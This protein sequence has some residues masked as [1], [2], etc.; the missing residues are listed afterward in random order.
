MELI[1]YDIDKPRERYI[2]RKGV[3]PVIENF[4]NLFNQLNTK[5]VMADELDLSTE[6]GQTLFNELV[7]S[8]YEGDVFTNVP[9]CPCGH[10]VGGEKE[11]ENCTRC[12]Y[13]CQTP[14]EQTIEPLVWIRAPKNVGAFLNPQVYQMLMTKMMSQGF[15]T[16][17]WLIDPKYKGPR[18]NSIQE[19]LLLSSKLKRGMKYFYENLEH[20]METVFAAR[21]VVY[22]GTKRET[23]VLVKT[24]T[25]KEIRQFLEVVK[26][27]MFASVLPFPSKIGFIIE[28]V[29][30]MKYIDPEMRPALNAMISIAKVGKE[31]KTRGDAE[32]RVARATRDLANYYKMNEDAKI[33]PKEG[34]LRKLVYGTT[35]HFTFRT[36]I[37][38]EHLPHDHETIRIPWGAAVMMFKLHIGNKVLKENYTPNQWLALIYDNVQRKHHKLD[39]IFDELIE[40]SPGGRGPSC[41]FTRFPSLKH[42]SSS[43]FYINVK[44]EPKHMSTSMSIIAVKA[45]NAD[46]VLA[47]VTTY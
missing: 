39:K 30:S 38:S 22:R 7:Y 45:A 33:F 26:D 14:T 27:D 24:S 21:T 31:C 34:V 36:V 4:D 6:E 15:S 42:N 46:S 35:P 20:V 5:P 16:L 18:L 41:L 17:D 47:V 19:E 43:R 44:R 28:N 29:G 13:T 2:G 10:T 25:A 37:T 1:T 11:G 9:R 12:G 23:V 8:R 40:E 32:S 3:Y